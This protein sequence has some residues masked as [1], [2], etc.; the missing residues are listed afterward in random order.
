MHC[1]QC[2]QHK[3][4]GS[5]RDLCGGLFFVSHPGHVLQSS[6]QLPEQNRTWKQIQRVIQASPGPER[7]FHIFSLMLPLRNQTSHTNGFRR[8]R[9]D[10]D[11]TL[12]HPVKSRYP[13]ENREHLPDRHQRRQWECRWHQ[14]HDFGGFHSL[15]GWLQVHWRREQ[16][17]LW[18]GVVD[19]QEEQHFRCLPGLQVRVPGA[20][21]DRKDDFLHRG[22]ETQ[23]AG[24][25]GVLVI[26]WIH[27]ALQ[28]V[29][30]DK[31]QPIRN[32]VPQSPYHGLLS[33][34]HLDHSLWL[35][36]CMIQR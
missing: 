28:Y 6:L 23:L 1:C 20:G 24:V 27:L 5:R 36:K 21:I 13:Q 3:S 14:G 2:H 34:I 25:F 35:F 15:L 4:R 11:L 9:R 10:Q 12:H 7:S 8:Q 30:V 18:L 26:G 22:Q 33:M 16:A 19:F 29:G 32:Q 31:D 17:E